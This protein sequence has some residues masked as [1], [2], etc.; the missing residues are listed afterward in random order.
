MSTVP[1]T[2][3]NMPPADPMTPS[4]APGTPNSTT[5]S[6]S[7]LSTSVV[8]HR[9]ATNNLLTCAHSVAIKDG[10]RG[11]LPHSHHSQAPTSGTLDAERA[12]RI[13]RLAGLERVT[14]AR[15][16]T[17]LSNLTPGAVAPHS[18]AASGYF[19]SQGNP[20]MGRERSTVG[21]ASATGSVGGRTTW[22][23]G[24]DVFDHDKMSESQDMDMETSSVGAASETNSLVGFGEG[25]RTP[26][27]HSAIGSPNV[28]KSTPTAA[29]GFSQ[30]FQRDASLTPV[31]SQAQSEQHDVQMVDRRTLDTGAETAERIIRERL[32]PGGGQGGIESPDASRGPGRD[33][34]KFYFESGK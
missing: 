33:L 25:A 13:S 27:R 20:L 19:D 31:S 6:M 12:D 30:P 14:T 24:S 17:P 3:I 11:H 28:A 4:D 29:S 34:G 15:N 8:L 22:A 1:P 9:R 32:G 10:H 7:E 26:A 16:P 2:L 23:S 18:A 5:T 21:S